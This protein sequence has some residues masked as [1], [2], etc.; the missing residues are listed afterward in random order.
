MSKHD[1]AIVEMYKG[2]QLDKL[3][4]ATGKMVEIPEDKAEFLKQAAFPTSIDQLKIAAFGLGNPRST[5]S[6]N[7]LLRGK[8]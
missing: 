6:A 4:K 7:G 3:E 2:K 8:L 1:I 5:D